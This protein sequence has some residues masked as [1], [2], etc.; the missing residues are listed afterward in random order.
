MTG[1][2]QGE[3]VGILRSTMS[4]ATVKI[5][6]SRQQ[7]FEEIDEREIVSSCTEYALCANIFH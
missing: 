6:V 4:G 2:S 3:V 7:E 5:V 1:K